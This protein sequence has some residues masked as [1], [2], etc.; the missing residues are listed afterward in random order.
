MPLILNRPPRDFASAR[1]APR[2]LHHRVLGVLAAALCAACSRDAPSVLLVVEE[3]DLPAGVGS[4]EPFLSSA[5]DTAYLSWLEATSDG[6]HAL[7]FARYESGSWTEPTVIAESGR[8]F[9]NWADFPSVSTGPDGSL[10]AHWLERGRGGGYDYGIRIVHS[11]DGG[12]S[13]S[14]PW[15]PHEDGTA[16][17]HGFV[18]T[19]RMGDQLGFLWLDGRQY[20]SAPNGALPTDEMALYFRAAGAEGPAGPETLVDA[21]VCDCCQTDMAVTD[22]GPVAVYRDRSPEEIRDIR[23]I[24][25]R[26]GVWQEGRIVHD[27]GWETGA[28]PVNGPAVAARGDRVA[29]AWFTAAG[30]V[31]R[32]KVAFSDDGGERFDDPITIDGGN[33]AGRVDVVMLEDGAALVSWL[34]RTGGE[35]AEVRV[36]RVQANGRADGPV[37]M[38]SSSGER[39]SGFPRMTRTGDG[40][41]LVAWTDVAE[42]A[43]RVRLARVELQEATGEGT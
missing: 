28:C 39:A 15:T 4:G 37:R 41:V 9:V 7:R 35:F 3:L 32:V 10:W 20:A 13:W 8:F 25:F 22:A 36:R 14:Q 42:L 38:S 23:I 33:P 2:R 11:R 17:E 40:V 43:P 1:R 34:E 27:D 5:G 31:P 29:V 30:D 21:R 19:A 16:T 24:H 12:S 18:S 26:D 6:A